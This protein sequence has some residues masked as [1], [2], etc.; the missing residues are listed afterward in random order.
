M[1]KVEALYIGEYTN[2]KT[3]KFRQIETAV[4]ACIDVVEKSGIDS[5]DF[6][7]FFEETR[8]HEKAHTVGFRPGRTGRIVARGAVD[9]EGCKFT[10]ENELHPDELRS[11]GFRENLKVGL[12]PAFIRGRKTS[13]PSAY[14][15]FAV[16][17]N[18][19]V[20]GFEKLSK[21]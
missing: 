12:A 16:I 5:A 19:I 9:K 20:D 14:D 11:F 18:G 1:T 10:I 21:K 3:E 15:L 17:N 13:L 6:L 2:R 4:A 7:G 8:N